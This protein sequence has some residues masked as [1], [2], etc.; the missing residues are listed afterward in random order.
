MKKKVKNKDSLQDSLRR[1]GHML[2]IRER[3]GDGIR[4]VQSKSKLSRIDVK[5]AL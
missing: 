1:F 4:R 5:K 2:A 3:R